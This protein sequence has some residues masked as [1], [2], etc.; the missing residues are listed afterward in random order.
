MPD[1]GELWFSLKICCTL[2]EQSYNSYMAQWSYGWVNTLKYFVC[3]DDYWGKGAVSSG[4]R[5]NHQDPRN[6][7]YA[8][9]ANWWNCTWEVGEVVSPEG[10][11]SGVV[12]AA[13]G[14]RGWEAGCAGAPPTL[15][16]DDAA[17]KAWSLWEGV[18]R[19]AKQHMG[20]CDAKLALIRKESEV[21]KVEGE[22]VLK[23]QR[24]DIEEPFEQAIVSA[25]GFEASWR[26]THAQH[27]S[28]AFLPRLKTSVS[29]ELLYRYN[30]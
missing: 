2:R 4:C 15:H 25:R 22:R 18:L 30:G 12:G 23:R 8:N 10:G 26:E 19:K 14:V 5:A 11:G 28:A 24:V 17:G 29:N 16:G 3:L 21:K 9:W 27:L 6:D 1:P 13:G 7:T 20:T